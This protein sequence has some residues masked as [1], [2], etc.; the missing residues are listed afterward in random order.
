MSFHYVRDTTRPA[1]YPIGS[2][3]MTLK[4]KMLEGSALWEDTNT[5]GQSSGH[6]YPA[7]PVRFTLIPELHDPNML[8]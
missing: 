5:Q 8:G 2:D 1:P 4:A 6:T 7:D 3:P